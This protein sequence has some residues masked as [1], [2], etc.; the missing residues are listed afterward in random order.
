MSDDD[1]YELINSAHWMPRGP[2][3]ID[4]CERAIAVA[5]AAGDLDAGFEARSAHLTACTFGGAADRAITSFAWCL[6]RHDAEPDRFD[7]MNWK[8][9]WITAGLPEFAAV[10][11]TRIDDAIE[12]MDRRFS[13]G[14]GG[15]VAVAKIR[16]VAARKMGDL[17]TA[18]HW[19]QQW[20]DRS[21]VAGGRSLTDCHA[22]DVGDHAHLL[23]VL[24]RHDEA[25]EL[26]SPIIEGTAR[27]G[28]IPHVTFGVLLSSMVHTGRIE[29]AESCHRR[30]Y[31]LVCS[32]PEFLAVVAAHADY[33]RWAGRVDDAVAMVDLHWPWLDGE[34]SD[35]RRALFLAA[36]ARVFAASGAES[37]ASD[38]DA[39]RAESALAEARTLA[40]AL[41][42]RNGNSFYRS[43]CDV[44]PFASN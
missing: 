22:C 32:N 17:D 41:D 36:A 28:E 16:W 21:K 34:R 3:Q 23:A 13:F 35:L 9:K 2:A 12:D 8:Y 29:L 25:I 10:P 38:T 14:G 26:A 6:A 30:G 4:A 31:D 20:L 27:C 11:R 39:T 42:Q 15:D 33:L 19:R 24:G 5:D 40:G 7:D 43:C 44:D 18:D 37:P 1:P